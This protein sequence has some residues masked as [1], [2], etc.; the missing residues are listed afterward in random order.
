MAALWD[1][2]GSGVRELLDSGLDKAEE[3]R[4]ELRRQCARN[5]VTQQMSSKAMALIASLENI[6]AEW[7][8]KS[9]RTQAQEENSASQDLKR[10]VDLAPQFLK[11]QH[12]L[13]QTIHIIISVLRGRPRD[14]P[15]LR[16]CADRLCSVAGDFCRGVGACA[17]GRCAE[18]CRELDSVAQA[19][20]FCFESEER[21]D[22]WKPW[23]ICHQG[24]GEGQQ[25]PRSGRTDCPWRKAVPT[26]I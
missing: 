24:S 22:A 8:T 10:V 5:E 13:E 6:F 16:T 9:S 12:C 20:L 15:L 14:G 7:R 17:P 25:H 19:L 26:H 11:L 4:R 18:S 3:L 1:G 23:D 2:A 21:A